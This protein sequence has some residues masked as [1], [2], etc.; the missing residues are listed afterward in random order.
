MLISLSSRRKLLVLRSF[1]RISV[2]LCW[3]SGWVTWWTTGLIAS[4][5]QGRDEHTRVSRSRLRF[6]CDFHALFIWPRCRHFD[7]TV[8]A[9]HVRVIGGHLVLALALEDLRQPVLALEGAVD[10]RGADD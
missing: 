9:P 1:C 8:T 4:S 6:R 10:Q 2:S 3:I 7:I 5:E